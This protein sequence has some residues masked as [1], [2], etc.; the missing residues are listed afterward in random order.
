MYKSKVTTVALLARLYVT[1][2]NAV[3][4]AIVFVNV[5]WMKNEERSLLHVALYPFNWKQSMIQLVKNVEGK[6]CLFRGDHTAAFISARISSRSIDNCP[7]LS[8]GQLSTEGLI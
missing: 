7:R 5:D 3:F 6:V 8:R 4:S 2:M 1:V